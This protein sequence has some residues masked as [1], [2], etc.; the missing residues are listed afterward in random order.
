MRFAVQYDALYAEHPEVLSD[1]SN[2]YQVYEMCDPEKFVPEGYAVVRIDTRGAGRSPGFLDIWSLR[3]AQDYATASN[4]RR[5]KPWSN[6]KI[7]LQ[8]HLVPGDEPVAGR[9]ARS[10]RISSA[11]FVF[12]GAYDYYRDM[13]RHG[14]I[15]CTFSKVLYGPAILSVQ[16]GRGRRGPRSPYRRA[17][18]SPV[19]RR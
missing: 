9:G 8:R 15:L 19:R 5:G 16:H 2:N 12:E 3:E 17:T 4:G 13:V 11:M 7:G 10:R 1:S 18:G 6:G 14:G